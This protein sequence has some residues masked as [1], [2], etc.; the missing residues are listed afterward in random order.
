MLEKA[1]EI[2]DEILAARFEIDA[3][4]LERDW[5]QVVFLHLQR[6]SQALAGT[7]SL[8][9]EGLYNPAVVLCRHLFEL[10]VNV[11]YLN[12][13]P[14]TRVPKYLQHGMVV[15]DAKEREEVDRRLQD[16]REKGDNAGVSKLLVPG[17]SWQNL[18][19]MCTELDCLD[20]YSTMYR[21]ASQL[22]HA[23]AQGLGREILA[24]I[25]KPLMA[26]TEMPGVLL[27]AVTY[28]QWVLEVCNQVFPGRMLGFNFDPSW[29]ERYDGLVEEVLAADK[30]QLEQAR[31]K[32]KAC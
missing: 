32:L 30:A 12:N 15:A 25:D 16:L 19:E 22:A 28:Y 24:L 14:D 10:G 21:S 8:A 11:K 5:H 3:D 20:H 6:S 9:V 4:D 23:G 7:R 29:T 31:Q 2:T 13:D 17:T 27:T 1:I 26:E 18:K